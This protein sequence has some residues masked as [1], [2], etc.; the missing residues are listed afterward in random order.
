MAWSLLLSATPTWTAC[1]HGKV[2]H[3]SS[4]F[5]IA[6]ASSRFRGKIYVYIILLCRLDPAHTALGLDWAATTILESEWPVYW[7][8]W[9]I[10][11]E[12]D[13]SIVVLVGILGR[14]GSAS[15]TESA[16]SS[17]AFHHRSARPGLCL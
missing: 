16:G 11:Y 5:L 4:P 6:D 17:I 12:L 10:V 14:Q 7:T 8:G 13:G 2:A 15:F 1:L 9:R 3:C